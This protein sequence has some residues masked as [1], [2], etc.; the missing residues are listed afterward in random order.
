VSALPTLQIQALGAFKVWVDGELV[1]ESRWTRKKAKSLLKIL[2]L[3]KSHQIHREQLMDLLWPE[4]DGEAALNNLHKAIH[5]ARR[6][7][8]PGLVNGSDS[9]FIQ[10]Q[11][12]ILLLQCERAL[13]IDSEAFDQAAEAA[14]RQDQA[15]PLEAAAALYKADLLEED[16][17][18]DWATLRRE[19]LRGRYQRV[20]DR[21]ADSYAKAGNFPLAALT[22]EKLLALAPAN[23]DAH[24][25]LIAIHLASGQRH[26]A[27]QQYKLCRQVLQDDFGALPEAA[28]ERLYE[29]IQAGTEPPQNSVT[30]LLVRRFPLLLVLGLVVMLA[31]A[32]YW[33]GTRAARPKINSVA[34]FPLSSAGDLAQLAYV[35]DG[36]TENIINRLSQLPNL[37]VMARSTVFSYRERKADPRAAGREM[38]VSA[39]VTG[40]ISQLGDQLKI[41]AELVDVSDGARLWGQQFI[42]AAKDLSTVQTR[43]GSEIATA[44]QQKL[45]AD[46]KTNLERPSTQ[47]PAAF[48]AFLAGLFFLNQRS[49]EGFN[50]AILNFEEAVALDPSFAAAHAGLANAHGLRAFAATRPQP[51]F[52]LARQAAQRALALDPNLAEAHTSIAMIA[53]LFDW[54]WPKAES[55]FRQAIA[56][57]PGY[58]TAHHWFAVHLAA[59]SR[60]EESRAVDLD[61]LSAIIRLNSGYP[62]YYQRRFP[63]AKATYRQALELNPGFSAA[64]LEL[65]SLAQAEGDSKSFIEQS[66]L[67]LSAEGDLGLAG[68]IENSYQRGGPREAIRVWLDTLQ[69]RRK[70]RYVSPTTIARLRLGRGEFPQALDALEQAL[71]ERNAALVY[72]NVNPIYDPLRNQPRFSAI[73]RQIGLTPQK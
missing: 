70:D 27:L 9:R 55:E 34:V 59:M 15:A 24:R 44:L 63:P 5:A 29:Q 57:N 3:E 42:V 64:H 45:S 49:R 25:R 36:I 1:D 67:A 58:S 10:T 20:L 19:H 14:V 52:E 53:A 32:A 72:L 41:N 73:L 48:K 46:Q 12:H 39:V 43:L 18:E 4:L 35:G 28:T 26:L 61:P 37:R 2:A 33:Y 7:L 13:R 17:F 22:L 16:R 60:F 31:A 11:N 50:K 38:N 8:E 54:D 47:N 30:P 62:D 68:A 56:L 40:S 71:A 51:E 66:V 21:L 69:Q 6:A 23:E 65:A